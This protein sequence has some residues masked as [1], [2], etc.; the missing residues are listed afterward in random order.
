MNADGTGQN[1]LTNNFDLDSYPAWSPDGTKLAFASYRDLNWE[2]Y[3]MNAADGSSQTNLTL[4][5]AH[6]YYPCWSPD[7]T[8]IVYQSFRDGDFEIY[9]MR[10]DG[11]LQTRLTINE[12]D[13]QTPAWFGSWLFSKLQCTN[14][15]RGTLP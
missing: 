15:C 6:D 12:A 7:G 13:D 3:V 1:N 9:K 11:T 4:S 14:F 8:Q 5:N 2:I 10:V